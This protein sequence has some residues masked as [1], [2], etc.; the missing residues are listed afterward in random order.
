MLTLLGYRISM[1]S[2]VITVA[3]GAGKKVVGRFQEDAREYRI[4]W[5]DRG[6]PHP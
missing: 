4:N 6:K 3:V 5:G 2:S 1:R